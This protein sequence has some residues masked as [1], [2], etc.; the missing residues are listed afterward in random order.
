MSAGIMIV[1]SYFMIDAFLPETW[2]FGGKEFSSFGVFLATIVGLVAGLGVGKITEY[3][4]GTGTK[5]VK[6]IVDQSVTGAAT[7]IIAG[8]GVGMM[9]TAIPILLIAAAIILSFHFAGLYGIAIAAVGMLANTGIQLA[10]DAYGPISDNAGGIAEMAEL[11]KEVRERT[12]KLDAVGN[13]T[14][15]IGKGFAIASAALTALALFSAFMQQANI[16]SIDIS[17]STVMAGLFVGGMLPFVFSAL[18]MGAVGKAAMSMI[19]EVRRQFN[20]IPALKDALAIMKKYDGDLSKATPEDRA[21]FDKADGVAEYE[22]C[23]AISTAASIKEMVIPGVLAILTPVLVGFIGGP[24]MLGGLL[25]GVTVTGV[26]MAIFQS[27]A[28]GAW[29]NAKKMFEGGVDIQGK[30]YHKGQSH[31]KLQL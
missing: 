29:D 14:A 22:K 1:V 3:Y 4:T 18:S 20:E 8:L 11:P 23:V 9:S 24:E 10:V 7:N 28:G 2:V 15:A 13:T 21:I 26:L 6:S 30:I 31:I 5:P 16:G 12:D 17:K 19:Q 25:A 27:N